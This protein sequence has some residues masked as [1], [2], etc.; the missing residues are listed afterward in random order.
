MTDAQFAVYGYEK[1]TA[2]DI[3]EL[4]DADHA[5]HTLIALTTEEPSGQLVTLHC[6]CGSKMRIRGNN[7]RLISR[8]QTL[9]RMW[10][11]T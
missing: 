3:L 11:T 8:L 10:V 2:R 7:A 6:S 9:G 1:A 5:L 4:Y